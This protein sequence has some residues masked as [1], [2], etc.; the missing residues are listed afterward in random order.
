[1][2]EESLPSL[3]WVCCSLPLSSTLE[4]FL[5]SYRCKCRGGAF[6]EVGCPQAPGLSA[7][8]INSRQ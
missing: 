8:C 5:L 1:M 7:A 3:E 6:W 4:C 2:Q